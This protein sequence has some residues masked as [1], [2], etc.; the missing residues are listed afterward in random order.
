MEISSSN[1]LHHTRTFEN[2]LSIIQYGF[3]HRVVHESLPFSEPPSSMLN[4]P[5]LIRYDYEFR[6]VCFTDLPTDR[7]VNHIEQYGKYIIGL[8]KDWGKFNGVTPI[9][10]VH[11]YTPDLYNTTFQYIRN[12][13][14]N[15]P[16]S[17]SNIIETVNEILEES[18]L[19]NPI[20]TEDIEGLPKK[21]Q[22]LFEGYNTMIKDICFHIYTHLGLM[23]ISEEDKWNEKLGIHERK[24]YYNEREWRSLDLDGEKGNL[25]FYDSDI[26]FIYV[27]TEKEKNDLI[28]FF[29]KS[30]TEYRNQK[31]DEL[32]NK[33]R[34]VS[35]LQQTNQD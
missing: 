12:F 8:T 24:N 25:E 30:R 9:R 19:E 18:G 3:E 29:K 27:I 26:S 2:L 13:V 20:T 23:R 21:I 22:Y 11:H 16:G 6:A 10:Y 1:L 32:K 17:K 28:E 7:I 14:E 34:L 31:L 15:F 35:E 5:G 33:I 4:I